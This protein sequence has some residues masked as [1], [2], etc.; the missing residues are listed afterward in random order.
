MLKNYFS[1]KV[2]T[3]VK[4]SRS[5]KKATPSG[6]SAVSSVTAVLFQ[7]D[8]TLLSAGAADGYLVILDCFIKFVV[9]VMK[10]FFL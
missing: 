2:S 1:L 5:K 4:S 7:N 3:E 6:L 9:L 8:Y 10:F